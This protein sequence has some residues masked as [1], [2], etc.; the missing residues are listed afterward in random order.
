MEKAIV[1]G[2]TG[3]TGQ[4]IV[5]ELLSRNKQVIAFGRS[6]KKL[7]Q[8]MK[9]HH[10]T[11]LLTYKLGDVFDYKT[12]V[13]AAKD[14]DVI[15][16]CANVQYHEMA[17]KLLLLGESV[18]KA[19]NILGK[20]IVIVDGIYVYGRQVAKGD[21]NHPKQP[22]TKKGRIRVDFENLIFN[23]RWT[24][25]K[26]LIVR[27]PDYYG[28]TSQNSYLH[29]T[30]TGMAANKVSVFIGNLKTPREY[31]YLPDAA[32][33]IVE[34]AN[35]DDSYGENW[36]IP[37]AGLISGKD[38]IKIVRDI[39][40]HSKLVIPLNKTAIRISGLFDPIMKEVVEIMYLTEEAFVLSGEKYEKRI[41]K[42]P[43]T[44]YQ[45]GLK[46]TL[47]FLMKK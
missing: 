3:G 36:N 1:L 31:V 38:I 35:K 14:A 32:K 45:Q 7:K 43:A 22:H 41:G 5:S 34:I 29:P 24:Y 44:S 47:H 2:A 10:S 16:Q 37:G 46:E 33:M 27:L 13:E 15:F 23:K 11:A 21:E 40:G 12:I 17:E 25:A 30:L 6:E 39:T 26:P 20:K 8:L 19:A 18:M 42:I 28:K 4:A 9:E